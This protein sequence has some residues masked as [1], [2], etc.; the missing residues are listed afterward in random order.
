MLRE[1]M[2]TPD[3]QTVDGLERLTGAI[4]ERLFAASSAS[5]Y[6][7]KGGGNLRFFFASPRYSED[8]DLDVV[9]GGVATLKKNGF[10]ILQDK[11]FARTMQSATL[12]MSAFVYAT[13]RS[14][15]SGGMLPADT[16]AC[17]MPM[18]GPVCV[19]AELSCAHA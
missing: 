15:C 3:A 19:C 7:L 13:V 18:T 1:L 12:S 6:V 2:T 4:L 16:R 8:M 5:Q 9:A 10:K 14:A 11:S 17:S